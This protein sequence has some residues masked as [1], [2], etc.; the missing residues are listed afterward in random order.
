MR[1]IAYP[2]RGRRAALDIELGELLILLLGSIELANV[3]RWALQHGER[4][5][6]PGLEGLLRT[7]A[8]E[9]T[10]VDRFHRLARRDFERQGYVSV[11][12]RP[13]TTGQRGRPKTIDVSLFDTSASEETRLELGL[14]TKTKLRDDAQKLFDE[15]ANPFLDGYSVR[16][17]FIALWA[18]REQATKGD[19]A[20]QWMRTFLADAAEVSTDAM[21][22]RPLVASTMDLF[23]ADANHARYA[24]VGLFEVT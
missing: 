17:N 1:R 23:I 4:S 2:S 18:L 5:A 24:V 19:T 8:Y 7:S 12:E 20:R 6:P 21:T 15:R 3:E 13:L 9:V 22:V 14:Y 11:W 10:V 16:H